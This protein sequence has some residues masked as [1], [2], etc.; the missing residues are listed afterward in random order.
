MET[1]LSTIHYWLV[2]HPAIS[3]YEWKEGET[4]GASPLFA[5]VTAISYLSVTLF[6]HRFA[7]LPALSS[8]ALRRA[9]AV[10]SMI[11][12]LLSLSMAVGG[13]LATLRQMPAIH[14]WR[15]VVCFPA[16]A[17]LPRG[18]V[19]F[20]AHV[21]YFSKILEFVDTLLI[22]LSGSRSRRLSFLHVF[23]H[24]GVVVVCYI[25]LSTAQTLIPVALVT[26]A[27]VHV[28]MYA[29]YFLSAL[30][31][32]PRWKKLVTNCQIIQF[33]FGFMI[34]GL[35][36]YYHLTGSGC[37]GIWAWTFNIVFVAL[38]LTMFL[39]FHSSNYSS[40]KRKDHDN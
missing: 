13:T 28:L 5:A 8:A 29:Y 27:A 14:G 10:H 31:H 3:Q 36:L 26:N 16:A 15:W 34:S 12:C 37:S 38:L 6:L 23:H 1:L 35:M 21:S 22:L 19:F 25:A 24:G 33:V 30:G 11:L 9:A 18:P 4:L 32:R 7:V 40:K 2:D 17:T 39:D 20:W